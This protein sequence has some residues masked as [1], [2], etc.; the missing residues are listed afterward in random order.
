MQAD[1]NWVQNVSPLIAALRRGH[2]FLYSQK[3]QSLDPVTGERPYQEVLIRYLEEERRMLPPGMFLPVLQE[4]GLMSLLD[5]WVVN[6]VLKLQEA[7]IAANPGWT[8]PRNSINLS[9]DSLVDPEFSDFVITQ[10]KARKV[11][12]D[13]LSFEIA[14]DIAVEHAGELQ[15]LIA[16][17]QPAD[18]SFAITWFTG[19]EEGFRLIESLPISFVKIDGSLIIRLGLGNPDM[20][21]RVKAIQQR[22]KAAH[23]RTIAEQVEDEKLLTLV[24][25]LGVNYAQGYGIS[26]PAPFL[27]NENQG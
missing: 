23:I 27:S 11:G 24:T 14:E 6:Q 20:L 3:I 18:C 17:L 7:A 21:E 4:Q 19:T 10:L 16:E 22:C 8:P 12:P 5:C 1:P 25:D 13:T 15:S 9:L 2:Y 26:M